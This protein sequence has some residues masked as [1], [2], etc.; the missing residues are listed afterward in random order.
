[1]TNDKGNPVIPFVWV[2]VVTSFILGA[3]ANEMIRFL[4]NHLSWVG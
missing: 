1:M 3:I 4:V 2:L